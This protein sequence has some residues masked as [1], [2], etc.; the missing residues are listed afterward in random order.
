MAQESVDQDAE[1]DPDEDVP[2]DEADV[3]LG[4]EDWR[5][6]C[7]FMACRRAWR[8]VSGMGG[9]WY[10][11]LDPPAVLSNLQMLGI[12]PK[13]WPDVHY[14]LAFLEDE[15]RNHLNKPPAED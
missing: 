12:K 8:I 9:I 6:W 11:G 7:V 2:S 3:E 15:A 4:P 13:H 14:R 10:E 1:A 5:A